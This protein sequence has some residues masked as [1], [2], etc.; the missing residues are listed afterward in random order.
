M[1]T[2]YAIR[3]FRKEYFPLQFRGFG[4]PGQCFLRVWIVDGKFL[5]LCAQ[6]PEYFGTSITNAIEAIQEAV[7]KKL[8][9]EKSDTG[10]S[11]FEIRLQ[12]PFIRSLI[13]S[14]ASIEADIFSKAIQ[15]FLRNCL[16]IEHYP[17]STGIVDEDSYSIVNF[18]HDGAP[19][20]SYVSRDFIEKM[21][22]DP[23]FIKI[24]QGA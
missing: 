21:L 13:A 18:G 2:N 3:D 5:V 24:D 8:L 11:V 10:E 6:L 22:T 7:V 20:W 19:S 17:R 16:W 4:G 1:T 12:F 23:T 15:I 14:K 9:G